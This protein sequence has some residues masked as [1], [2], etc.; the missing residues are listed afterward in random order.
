MESHLKLFLGVTFR[1]NLFYSLINLTYV[2]HVALTTIPINV[3]FSEI[4][5]PMAFR[6]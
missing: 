5:K 2:F 6:D 3:Q 1:E 4:N